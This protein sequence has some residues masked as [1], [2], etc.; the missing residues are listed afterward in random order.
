[1]HDRQ[2]HTTDK[3]SGVDSVSTLAS[4]APTFKISR[5][6]TGRERPSEDSKQSV[7]HVQATDCSA[8]H[9]F[10]D[11][12]QMII[13]RCETPPKDELAELCSR[14][15]TNVVLA[16]ARVH[17]RLERAATKHVASTSVTSV[18]RRQF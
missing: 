4:A 6:G 3:D 15:R 7:R 9:L 13:M 17:P 1:M 8:K 10:F 12:L 18:T 5:L 11:Q 2:L 16:S 14:K